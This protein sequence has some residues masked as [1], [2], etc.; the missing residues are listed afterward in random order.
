MSVVTPYT[1]HRFSRHLGG[2]QGQT[3]F[4]HSYLC[5]CFPEI[6][7]RT[8]LGQSCLVS[9]LAESLDPGSGAEDGS[10]SWK[11]AVGLGRNHALL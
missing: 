11:S 10:V 7:V 3:S 8:P 1:H 4:L 5:D 9:L 6:V 2:P